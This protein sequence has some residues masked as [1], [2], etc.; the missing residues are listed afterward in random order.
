M[1]TKNLYRIS[2]ALKSC[3]TAI[4]SLSNKTELLNKEDSYT[5]SFL[6]EISNDIEIIEGK[7]KE[8]EQRI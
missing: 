7:I 8:Y 5:I 2:M 6:K 1:E 3:K 4:N